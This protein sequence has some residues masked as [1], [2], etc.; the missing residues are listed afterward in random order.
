MFYLEFKKSTS[1]IMG[2]KM[3]FKLDINCDSLLGTAE[4]NTVSAFALFL[5]DCIF[6]CRLTAGN[7]TKT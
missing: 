1:K 3:P 4:L 7:N 5:R 6:C 2:Q